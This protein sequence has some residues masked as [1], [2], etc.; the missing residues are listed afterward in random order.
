[1]LLAPAPDLGDIGGEAKDCF[2]FLGRGDPIGRSPGR[3]LVGRPGLIID[4]D[5]T[6]R[7]AK[8][9]LSDVV[10]L[11]SAFNEFAGGWRGERGRPA[12]RGLNWRGDKGAA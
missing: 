8:V 3:G 11:R 5:P 6:L 7:W 4:G 2:G 10:G 1:M 9:E 12:C